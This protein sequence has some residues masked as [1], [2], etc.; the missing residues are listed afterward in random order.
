MVLERIVSRSDT[1]KKV[2]A[3]EFGGKEMK[4]KK[5]KAFFEQDDIFKRTTTMRSMTV[6]LRTMKT[7]DLDLGGEEA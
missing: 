3:T 6:K 7:S 4:D 2:H 1:K 5:Q